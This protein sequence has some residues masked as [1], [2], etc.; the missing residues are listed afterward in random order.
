[1]D[2][3]FKVFKMLAEYPVQRSFPP[4]AKLTIKAADVLRSVRQNGNI[5]LNLKDPAIRL[6]FEEGWIHSHDTDLHSKSLFCVL[7]SKLHEK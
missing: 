2:N 4:D 5:A 6:C 1:L 7:P 3:E